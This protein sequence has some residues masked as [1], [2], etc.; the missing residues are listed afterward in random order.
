MA[1][2]KKIEIK[3]S[4]PIAEIKK[5]DKIKVDGL[6]LEVDTHYVMIDHEDAK[7]MAIELFDSEKDKDYQIRYFLDNVENSIEFFELDEIVY[8][9]KEVERVEW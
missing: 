8:N 9:R 6:E 1:E 3:Q 7:E 4:K 5:G 2:D